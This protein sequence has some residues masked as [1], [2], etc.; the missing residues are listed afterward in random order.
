M[1]RLPGLWIAS[2]MLVFLLAGCAPE[3]T[4]PPPTPDP[5]GPPRDPAAQRSDLGPESPPPIAPSAP[6]DGDQTDEQG[7]EQVQSAE[8]ARPPA[9]GEQTEEPS[10][11]ESETAEQP[12]S[13]IEGTQR[14]DLGNPDVRELPLDQPVSRAPRP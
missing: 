5:M 9:T 10:A 2:G 7:T 11:L 12:A 4:V 3:P 6:A 1:I 13:E 14:E 8:T